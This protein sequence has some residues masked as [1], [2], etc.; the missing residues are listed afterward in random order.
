[1]NI[2]VQDPLSLLIYQNG[3]VQSPLVEKSAKGNTNLD[4]KQESVVIGTPIPIVFCRRLSNIGGVL[5]SPP[6]TEGRFQ[7]D[8]TTNVL[9]VYY[10]LV[11]SL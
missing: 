7:N 5:V 10:E 8:G 9:S 2:S 11:L 4:A 3:T 1:M 6:A